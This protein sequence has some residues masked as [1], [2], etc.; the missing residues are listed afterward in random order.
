MDRKV[1]EPPADPAAPALSSFSSRTHPPGFDD[2]MERKGGNLFGFMVLCLA[3]LLGWMYVQNLI[4]PPRE[5]PADPNAPTPV[6]WTKAG[7]YAKSVHLLASRAILA[8][9]LTDVCRLGLDAELILPAPRYASLDAFGEKT[10]AALRLAPIPGPLSLLGPLL[11]YEA[12]KPKPTE[13]AKTID[14]GGDGYFLQAKLTTKGAAVQRVVLTDFEAADY[15]GRPTKDK[16]EL[17][18]EDPIEPSYRL[19]HYPEPD[20]KFPV[21]TLGES[22]WEHLE[23]KTEESGT[24]VARF[25][26]KLTDPAYSHLAIIKSYILQPKAYHLGLLLEIQ[27]ERPKEASP[28]PAF[29]YQLSGAHGMPIE[30]EWYTNVYRNALIG[31]VDANGNLWRDLQDPLHISTENGG[32]KVPEQRADDWLQYAGVATQYFA[33]VIVVDDDQPPRS[34]GGTDMRNILAWARP[35]QESQESAGRI[36]VVGEDRLMVTSAEGTFGY[37]LLP[38]VRE[39]LEKIKLKE[40][41]RVVLSWYQTPAGR[42]V[43]TWIR[44]GNT[45]RAWFDDMTVRVNSEKFE[46]KP[47]QKVAHR[48]LLYHGPVKVSLLRQFG[49]AKAVPSDLVTRYTDKLH[50]RTLTDYASPG[51]FGAVSQKIMFTDLI[52]AVTKLM[53]TLLYWLHFLVGSYGVAIILL[54]VLVRGMMF[55]ISRKQA[56]FSAKMQELAPELKKLQEKY[57]NDPRARTEATME[58]YRK[59]KINPLGSCLPLLMQ[60]PIFLGLYFALQESIHFRLAPFLWIR[61]LAAPD[62]L[63][64]WSQSIPWISDPDN[65]GGMLYLGPFLNLLPIGAVALMVWQQKMMTPPA[66]DETQATQQKVMKYMMVFIGILFY[67]VAAGLCLYFI[68]SSLWGV[69][70]RKLLPKKDIASTAGSPPPG[71]KPGGGKPGQKDAPK[72]KQKTPPKPPTSMDKVKNWWQEVLKQAKKK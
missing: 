55:P 71:G 72:G 14:L 47:G 59:H 15:L 18:A 42:R 41:D 12:A 27:D 39:H 49:G 37:Y 69:A 13:A 44:P 33:S 66:A 21:L 36:D 52:I 65:I 24:Q 38:R 51:F 45:P 62:M 16:L 20:A 61:N 48:F 11:A 5:R 56:L 32:R 25:R 23:T 6:D 3:I 53:H 64:Y 54:T 57:K 26:I 2:A 8:D 10:R 7:P 22:V 9:P 30:G 17:V 31:M 19:F 43:A 70:E 46:V 28:G 63:L 29:R 60:L 40:K 68:A 4:W 34:A 58:F 35:T 1:R 50:L 67:K